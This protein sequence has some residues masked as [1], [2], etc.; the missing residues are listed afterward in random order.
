MSD[1]TEIFC[2]SSYQKCLVVMIPGVGVPDPETG[3]PGN[4]FFIYVIKSLEFWEKLLIKVAE[5][6]HIIFKKWF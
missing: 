2:V 1:S 5:R 3:F 6:S 4:R